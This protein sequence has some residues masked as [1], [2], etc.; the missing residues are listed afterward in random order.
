MSKLNLNPLADWGYVNNSRFSFLSIRNQ[1]GGVEPVPPEPVIPTDR[2]LYTVY[3]DDLPD[4]FNGIDSWWTQ[5]NTYTD[6]NTYD[7][8][9]GKGELILKEGVHIIEGYYDGDAWRSTFFESENIIKSIILPIQIDN[10]DNAAFAECNNLISINIPHSITKIGENVFIG[11][12]SLTSITI[13]DSVTEIGGGAFSG[14]ESLI[15]INIPNLITEIM[16]WTFSNCYN[17]PSIDLPNSVKA[18]GWRAFTGCSGLASINIPDSVTVIGE[19]AFAECSSLAS[20]TCNWINSNDIPDIGGKDVFDNTSENLVINI[21]QEANTM[22]YINK[23]WPRLTLPNMLRYTATTQ[24]TSTWITTNC[25]DNVFDA[26]T[27]EGYLVLNGG[28]DIIESEEGTNIF[29]DLGEDENIVSIVI[30]SQVTSIGSSAFW[31][32]ACLVDV[33][34]PNSVTTIGY[35]AFN[36]CSALTNITIPNSVTSI[37]EGAFAGCIQL[38]SVSIPNSVTSIG[39][40]AFSE[41]M[42][43]QTVFIPN[44]ITSIGAAV[45]AACSALVSIIIP[46]SVTSIGENAFNSCTSLVSITCEAT[47]P[48][49]L[50]GDVF[51][52]INTTT[53]KVPAGTVAAYEA[54]DWANYFTTFTEFT[55]INE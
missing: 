18:I 47:K 41:C 32:C 22:D 50:G 11:C 9:T 10:I 17:L 55:S 12:T 26:E 43:L 45:F 20:V 27:G 25:S 37:G 28:V 4:D 5:E 52:N 54:S 23:G 2:I 1:G 51:A 14:C 3:T 36:I 49:T 30:P 6:R 33:D 7:K 29:N 34:I 16:D 31:G 38:Q 39:D 42:A 8:N 19:E 46:S 48:P 13:P 15:S 21:P 53:C 24:P 44:S 35:G 40:V